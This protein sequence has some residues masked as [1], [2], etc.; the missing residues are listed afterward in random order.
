MAFLPDRVRLIDVGAFHGELF[1]ALG[2]RLAEGFGLEPL[3][4]ETRRGRN[5]KVE[6]GFFPDRRPAGSNWDAVTLLA[7]LEHIPRAQ[8]GPMAETCHD[9]L[10]PGGRVIITVPAARLTR[11]WPS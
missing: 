2:P 3:L 10:V 7:V 8:Q 6:P 4:P 9:L 1:E 5:F 11:F